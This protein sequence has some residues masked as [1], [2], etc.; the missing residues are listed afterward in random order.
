MFSNFRTQRYA[1]VPVRK[2]LSTTILL[3]FPYQLA[4]DWHRLNLCQPNG[5][6]YARE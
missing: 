1:R 2:L 4:A 5:E 3:G 6:S